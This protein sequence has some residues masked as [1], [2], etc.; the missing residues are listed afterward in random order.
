MIG[1]DKQ[2]DNLEF[3]PPPLPQ[4]HYLDNWDLII[5]L[6]YIDIL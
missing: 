2:K 4:N 1:G 3:T 5:V 6:G